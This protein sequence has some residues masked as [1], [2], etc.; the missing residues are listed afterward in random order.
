MKILAFGEILWD[1]IDGQ[2]HLGGAPLNFAAHAAQLGCQSSIVSAVGKDDRG[3]D[4][5]KR[6]RNYNVDA[7]FVQLAESKPT[8][9]VQVQLKNEQPHYV[10]IKDVAYD[11]IDFDKIELFKSLTFDAFYFGTLV[12]RSEQSR[13][14]LYRLLKVYSFKHRFCDL[15]LREGCFDKGSIAASIENCTIL[16]LNDEEVEVISEMLFGARNDFETF[17]Q[18][19]KLHFPDVEIMVITQ[20]KDG[21]TAFTKDQE[22][23]MPSV[24]CKVKDTI[25]AGDSF[26]ATFVTALLAGDPLEEALKK[27]NK[28][29]AFVASSDGAIPVFP[30]DFKRSIGF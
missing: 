4:A 26:S 25:G 15:N 23:R 22:I 2:E 16:K 24:P 30:S 3:T 6:L 28:V 19:V 18:N 1:I 5:I 21:C 12:Q 8:G 7:Q 29:G 17:W 9:T 20:G 13:E 11:Y 27:A 14:T 10:I